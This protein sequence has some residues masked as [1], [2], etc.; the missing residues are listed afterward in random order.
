MNPMNL[1]QMFN[2]L[3]GHSNPMGMMQQMFGGNPAFQQAM[4][5][6]RGKSPQE[7]Q[8]TLMN[9]AQTRGMSPQDVTTLMQNF[10]VRI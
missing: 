6:A 10:G 8:Q 3:N 7:L 9:L 1:M 5:M 4:N 2:Q